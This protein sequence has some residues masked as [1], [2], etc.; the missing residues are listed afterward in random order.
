MNGRY[1]SGATPLCLQWGSRATGDFCVGKSHV[2]LVLHSFNEQLL[3]EHFSPS[4][5]K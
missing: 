2:R 5:E 1:W 4:N 3:L